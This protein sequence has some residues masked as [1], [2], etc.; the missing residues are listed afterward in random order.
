MTERQAAPR[1]LGNQEQQPVAQST[2]KP[3]EKAVT[4]RAAQKK[5]RTNRPSA[6]ATKVRNRQRTVGQV[7]K[8]A[9]SRGRQP[10]STATKAQ[11]KRSAV[12]PVR[13]RATTRT[14]KQ[15]AQRPLTSVSKTKGMAAHATKGQIGNQRKG[16]V[17]NRKKT[18]LAKPRIV[19]KAV[20]KQGPAKRPVQAKRGQVG[21]QKQ[22]TTTGQ[23]GP[24]QSKAP[25]S[26]Q[27]KQ[28][29]RAVQTRTAAGI[30]SRSPRVQAKIVPRQVHQRKMV[31]RS[32]GAVVTRKPRQSS[33]GKS[34]AT[35][36][37]GAKQAALR[38]TSNR[39]RSQQQTISSRK[40]NARGGQRT[41][42]AQARQ[43]QLAVNQQ[44]TRMVQLN[45]QAV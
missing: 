8:K 2:I 40:S 32:Q 25:W 37:Q 38:R 42:T 23:P 44:K 14:H 13:K 31:V 41:S 34:T 21:V 35:I 6:G 3:I 17:V 1:A 36:Q 4:K 5:T 20:E 15:L 26:V 24:R 7:R 39:V 12:R 29:R 9:A 10:Q 27:A 18:A 30:K 22:R 43:Q 33:R 16:T 11:K 19:V 28:G 45:Q